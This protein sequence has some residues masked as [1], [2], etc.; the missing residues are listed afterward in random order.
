MG[1]IIVSSIVPLLS[2]LVGAALTYWLN[3]RA[4]QRNH[5]IDLFNEAIAAV[6]IADAS[7]HYIRD[8]AKPRSLTEEDHK[9][10]LRE[11]AKAAIENHTRHAG[12]ARA[13]LAQ[14]YQY[15]PSVRRYYQ[16]ATAVVDRPAEIITFLIETRSRL[17]G[18]RTR[19][20]HP[21]DASPNSPAMP[22]TVLEVFAERAEPAKRTD[23]A[24]TFPGLDSDDLTLED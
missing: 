24:S 19:K 12:E 13:A 10:L 7:Q 21:A 14:I 1:Q 5:V 4:R 20:V 9:D 11:I 6:A 16:D 2:V 3:V 18:Q 15:E 8:V 17:V 23:L 22:Q